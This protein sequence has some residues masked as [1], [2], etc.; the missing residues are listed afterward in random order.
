M[1]IKVG[2]KVGD[3]V[4]YKGPGGKLIPAKI[5]T[6]DE[7]NLTEMYL[8]E[9]T[10]NRTSIYRKGNRFTTNGNYLTMRGT[11]KK[12]TPQTEKRRTERREM[13]ALKALSQRIGR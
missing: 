4:T 9:V 10:T 13:E 11:S 7:S 2:F 8:I 5:V 1:R 3:N 6:V 12:A